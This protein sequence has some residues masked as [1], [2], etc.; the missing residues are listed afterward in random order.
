M[1]PVETLVMSPKHKKAIFKGT[2]PKQVTIRNRHRKQFCA[3]QIIAIVS[4][5]RTWGCRAIVTHTGFYT[6]ATIP[7]NYVR[8][9]GFADHKDMLEGMS[10]YYPRIG[11]SDPAT[12]ICWDKIFDW[13]EKD[14]RYKETKRWVKAC[15]DEITINEDGTADV[16]A[17][18]YVFRNC[19]VHEAPSDR[20]EPET[21]YVIVKH[22]TGNVLRVW[23]T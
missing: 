18:G 20:F 14:T 7:L 13:W 6:Y 12:V 3:G 19:E 5:D 2:D 11:P 10:R 22:P 9:D 4:S 15:K 23:W 17:W 8:A 16:F 21:S 1:I